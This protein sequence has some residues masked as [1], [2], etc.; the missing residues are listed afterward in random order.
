MLPTHEDSRRQIFDWANGEFKSAKALI[1]KTDCAVG[2]H[3]HRE[4]EEQFFLLKGK[5]KEMQ[6][7]TT[8]L[9]N[10][11]APHYVFVPRNT[12]HRFV[13]EEGSIL[14]GTASELFNPEDEIK[15]Q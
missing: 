10:V 12:Y 7:G 11:E 3:F 14:L 13:L 1:A 15:P 8:L 9:L 4:K 6:V 5:M 2:D